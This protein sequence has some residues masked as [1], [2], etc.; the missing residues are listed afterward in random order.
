MIS[1]KTEMINEFANLYLVRDVVVV[2]QLA[3]EY[4]F[5]R[6]HET[7]KTFHDKIQQY[8]VHARYKNERNHP[9]RNCLA[10]CEC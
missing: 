1:V 6:R 9:G 3:Y 7:A 4:K 8:F 2:T 10:L 5:W